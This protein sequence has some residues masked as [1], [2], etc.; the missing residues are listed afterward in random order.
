MHQI[1]PVV[2]RV[3]VSLY[4]PLETDDEIR[5]LYLQPR[6]GNDTVECSIEH[7]KL[8]HKP[9]YEALSYSWGPEIMETI[10]FEGGDWEVRENLLEALR[11][12]RWENRTRTLWVDALCINQSDLKE[13][14]Q[15]VA[16]MGEIYTQAL[17]V[18]AWIGV[19]SDS[20]PSVIQFILE[21][22]DVSSL[23]PSNMAVRCLY[24]HVP[25]EVWHLYN[26]FTA[27]DNVILG[28]VEGIYKFCTRAYWGRLWIVQEV[29][30]AAKV[31]IQCGTLSLSWDRLAAFFDQVKVATDDH[32]TG[33]VGLTELR[34]NPW[35][36]PRSVQQSSCN[37]LASA[38][39]HKRRVGRDHERAGKIPLL[40]LVSKYAAGAKCS[41]DRD[42]VLGLCGLTTQ[43]CFHV[44]SM[45]Y[46]TTFVEMCDKLLLHHIHAH[47]PGPQNRF[48]T[49]KCILP[50]AKEVF[51]MLYDQFQASSSRHPF[52]TF[53]R[54]PNLCVQNNSMND[55]TFQLNGILRS[56]I[57]YLTALHTACTDKNLQFPSMASALSR[58]L[59]Q[60]R[61]QIWFWLGGQQTKLEAIG[62]V[63]D[64]RLHAVSALGSY[65]TPNTPSSSSEPETTWDDKARKT[66]RKFVEVAANRIYEDRRSNIK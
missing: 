57:Q 8:S 17:G 30:L 62:R 19:A 18:I 22:A 44:V 66:F 29:L 49:K 42:R 38:R 39:V 56:R 31:T 53:Y 33:T 3:S 50:R 64:S 25:G 4:K 16:L 61:N 59:R 45:S 63:E 52:L 60:M 40:V 37:R 7:V 41:D 1:D 20:S 54:R 9:E 15:Q 65:P 13:R 10:Q 6:D 32:T 35:L 46:E 23:S 5:L 36:S 43:C 24:D 26:G 47:P 28:L 11:H 58:Y 51:G 21:L 12:L 55:D 14:L 2:Q 34:D 48:K 27:S